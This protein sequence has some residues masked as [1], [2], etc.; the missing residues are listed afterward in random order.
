MEKTDL[1]K[2]NLPEHPGVY[3]FLG[4]QKE[5]LYIGK[6]G[7]LKDRVR[8]YFSTDL[9]H[10]RGKLIV[11]MVE[12]AV[13]IDYRETDSVLEALMLEV[14]LIKTY[15]PKYNTREK[16]DK[17]FN[18]IV[19]TNEEY[20]RVLKVRS[21]ELPQKFTEE[22]IKYKFG[23]F[24]HGGELNE[25]LKIIRRIFPYFD[26]K[27]PVTEISE[28]EKKALVLNQ[29]I[30]LYPKELDTK[31]YAKTI[32]HL[33]LFF[34]G[35]KGKLVTELKKE[36]KAYADTKEFEKAEAVK[37][38]IFALEHIRDVSLIKEEI[39]E[40][41][42]FRIEA[43]DT[44]H[45]KGEEPKG[46]MVVAI[47]GELVTDEYRTFNL[48]S[49]GR[50][51]DLSG[52][53]EI[54]ERRFGHPEWEYPKLIVIDGGKTHLETAKKV[55]K[56]LGIEIPMVSVVK[57]EKHKPKGLLG[58][59]KL[60]TVHEKGILLANA[61]AHRFAIGRHRKALRKNTLY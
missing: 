19:I 30:G 50:G 2:A 25:A 31:E 20:P 15:K 39:K 42:G 4:A 29:Q 14:S 34:D 48:K 22:E 5:I 10:T 58:E 60:L 1:E 21:K 8:S 7:S 59:K 26:T 36:M 55:L 54:L 43:Y 37:R 16:D 49:V 52:L 6:A 41:S 47:D 56:R 61:E 11:Q 9:I 23:P 35:K 51:D 27:K 28:R 18:F 33:K 12:E 13:S 24:P 45:L 17:S 38:K 46:V 32:R 53:I 57:D 3:F 44:A 40:R